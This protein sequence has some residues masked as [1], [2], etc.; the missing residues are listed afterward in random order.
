MPSKKDLIGKTYNNVTILEELSERS[1]SNKIRYFCNCKLC[2]NTFITIGNNVVSGTTKNCRDC[3]YVK[4][5]KH[6]LCDTKI[7]AVWAVMKHRCSSETSMFYE[8]YKE[9]GIKVCERWLD[10]NNF[11][12][13]MFP[14]YQEGLSIDRIDNDGDYEPSNCKWSTKTEQCLN[15][16]KPKHCKSSN[17]RNVTKVSKNRWRASLTANYK[18]IYIDYFET[19]LDAALAVD[20]FIKANKL[21]NHLNFKE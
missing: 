9:R 19:E 4:N 7:Y 18:L 16:R 2:G 10:F 15:R 6:G 13:D 8:G 21:Q 17:Y 20:A 14:S 11:Y 1:S 5:R 12:E 3:G